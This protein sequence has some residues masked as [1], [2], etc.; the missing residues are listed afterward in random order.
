MTERVRR[1]VGAAS[2]LVVSIFCGC[3]PGV[4]ESG[5]PEPAAPAEALAADPPP[6]PPPAKEEPW[7]SVH[8]TDLPALPPP[9][10]VKHNAEA[11]TRS[12]GRV[13]VASGTGQDAGNHPDAALAAAKQ[14]AFAKMDAWLAGRR[15]PEPPKEQPRVVQSYIGPDGRAYVR[16]EL[17]LR[18]ER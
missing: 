16:A 6:L 7:I 18:A 8:P 11:E 9:A 12:R 3:T 13:L 2:A 4:G 10:W 15:M 17:D 5:P 14:E 1:R